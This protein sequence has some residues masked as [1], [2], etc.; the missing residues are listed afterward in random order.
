MGRYEQ[1]NEDFQIICKPIG[2]K[3]PSLSR[4]NPLWPFPRME[5]FLSPESLKLLLQYYKRDFEIFNYS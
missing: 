3:G 5:T 4:L 1:L 2:R